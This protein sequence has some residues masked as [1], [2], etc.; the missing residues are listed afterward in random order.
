MTNMIPKPNGQIYVPNR[1]L[2]SDKIMRGG[3]LCKQV[4][5]LPEAPSH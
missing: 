3:G 5:F 4:N 2:Q 1:Q